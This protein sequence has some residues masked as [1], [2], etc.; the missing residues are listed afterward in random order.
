MKETATSP[1]GVTRFGLIRH[2]ATLWNLEKRVQGQNDTPLTPEG[3]RDARRWGDVLKDL[4]W[5]RVLS[6]DTGR[7]VRTAELVNASLALPR[8]ADAGLREQDWGQWTGMKVSHIDA[9]FP[10]MPANQRGVGWDF[11]PP[12]GESRLQMWERGH[13]TLAGAAERWPGASILVVTHNGMIRCL[14]NR[15]LGLN[16]LH[17]EPRIIRPGHLHRLKWENGGLQID[18]A[19]ALDLTGP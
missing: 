7:A 6:S 2:A 18:A 12:E 10:G 1:Q 14:L 3:E 17:A 13:R 11:C 4:S 19:N 15:C 9:L 8:E 5:D 16:Y